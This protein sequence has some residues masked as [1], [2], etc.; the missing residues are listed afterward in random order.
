MTLGVPGNDT[1]KRVYGPT[2]GDI[3]KV[4]E[5][6]PPETP[7]RH[8]P[9]R[10]SGVSASVHAFIGEGFVSRYGYVLNPNRGYR[11]EPDEEVFQVVW[12]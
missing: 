11:P 9:E 1:P 7:V 2:A 4:L 6:V 8:I 5:K 12:I 3:I 10:S